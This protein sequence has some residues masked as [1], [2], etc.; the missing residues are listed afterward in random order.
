MQWSEVCKL[1][2]DQWV[3]VE[4]LKSYEENNKIYV[5]EVS[6][7]KP[8]LDPKEAMKELMNAKG[9][10]FVYHTSKERI[11]M[12]VRLKPSIRRHANEN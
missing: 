2:P 12:E 1:Y 4:E 3:L 6:V 10:R 8:I 11:V 9:D 7:I 5:E